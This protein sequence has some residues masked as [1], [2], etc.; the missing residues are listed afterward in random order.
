MK[1]TKKMFASYLGIHPTNIKPYYDD[2][3]NE[4]GLNRKYLIVSDIARL[5]GVT[6]D[7]VAGIMGVTISAKADFVPKL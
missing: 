5:D 6:I 1:V 3:L 7:Y 4:L 2:Y